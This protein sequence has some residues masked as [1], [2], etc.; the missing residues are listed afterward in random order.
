MGCTCDTH[1]NRPLEPE[2][3]FGS[4]I[5]SDDGV[6]WNVTAQH[7]DDYHDGDDDDDDGGD[8]DDDGGDDIADDDDD[9]AADD[10][11]GNE[12]DGDG[13]DD[14]II[15]MQSR[16]CYHRFDDIIMSISPSLQ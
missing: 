16:W 11:G 2:D 12:N 8:D 14:V 9:A 10:D 6:R 4:N 13:G 1:L 3:L 15:M 7:D 5:A